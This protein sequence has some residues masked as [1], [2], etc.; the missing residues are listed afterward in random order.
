[1]LEKALDM[2]QNSQKNY[3]YK[4]DQLKSIR[5][6]LTVQHIRNQLTVKVYMMHYAAFSLCF[7]LSPALVVI[8]SVYTFWTVSELVLSFCFLT[9]VDFI[10]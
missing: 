9:L 2:V 1:M 3:L 8:F 6:D 5:Q 7:P 4:C 10:I